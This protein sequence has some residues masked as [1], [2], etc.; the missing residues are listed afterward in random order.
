MTSNIRINIVTEGQT[1]ETFVNTVL[2][3]HLQ[4]FKIFDVRAHSITTSYCKGRPYRG[5]F[6]KYDHLKKDVVHW[7]QQDTN[8]YVTTMVDL[9]ALPGDFPNREKF[10]HNLNPSIKVETAEEELAKDI[11][12]PRFIPNIQ[13][14]E[15]EAALFSNVEQIHKSM[16]ASGSTS[17]D[18]RKLQTIRAGFPSP[19]YINDDPTT[20]P[21]KR[22]LQIYPSFQKT[23]DG[24]IIAKN[25]GISTIRKECAHFDKW[26]KILESLS[27]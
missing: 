21:S 14:H 12:N 27:H 18:L 4:Q 26:L 25:I 8:A 17:S 2:V 9:Y 24:I 13:L 15:F 23:T 3:D 11:N 7:L 10:I 16:I 6:C 1:E 5:G 19:E 20:A 22:I